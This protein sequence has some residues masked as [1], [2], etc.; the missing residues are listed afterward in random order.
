MK[1]H[2]PL[3]LRAALLGCFA[4]AALVTPAAADLTWDPAN[5]IWAV[6][7]PFA[8]DG[9]GFRQGDDVTFGSLN[10]ADGTVTLQGALEVGKMIVDAESGDVYTFSGSAENS[11]T[12]L[13]DG[14]ASFFL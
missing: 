9:T 8:S 5:S 3:S 12:S 2:L 13:T 10:G 4:A 11:I 14:G 6:D 7:E 1:L